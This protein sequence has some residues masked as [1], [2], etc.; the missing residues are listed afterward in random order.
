MLG[1][2]AQTVEINWKQIDSEKCGLQ[3]KIEKISFFFFN[4]L[5]K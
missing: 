3:D 1:N 4:I 5:K 2:C